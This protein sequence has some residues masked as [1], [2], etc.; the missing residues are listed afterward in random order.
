M[1][2]PLLFSIAFILV[3][4]HCVAQF[5]G[6]VWDGKP[7]DSTIFTFET[8]DS[9]TH[10]QGYERIDTTGTLL[11]KIGTTSKT[12]FAGAPASVKAIMTDTSNFYP[13]NANDWFVLKLYHPM[14]TIVDFYHKF[15]TTSKHAG[16]IV[17]Y[18]YDKGMNWSNVMDSCNTG[19]DQTLFFGIQ[20]DSF[21]KTTDTLFNGESAFTGVSNG[22]KYSRVQ[23]FNFLPIKYTGVASCQIPD[24][25]F[26]RFRFV[27]DTMVSNLDGWIIDNIKTEHDDYGSSVEKLAANRFLSIFPNPSIDGIINFPQLKGEEKYTVEIIN[28][29]GV[30]VMKVP[31]RRSLDLSAQPA[32]LYF[33]RVTNGEEYYGGSLLLR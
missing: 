2:K 31:Y 6:G 33:Y 11:W 14:N 21:Y 25:V 18:S 7:M 30:K 13:A 19:I 17:E 10:S 16:G 22:W 28:V 23:F 20:T 15:Q 1:K 8:N 9:L 32:G 26:L 3:N 29:Q 12:F 5:G 27:S 24:T 4:V